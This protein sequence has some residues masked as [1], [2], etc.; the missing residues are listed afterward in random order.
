MEW[1][2]LDICLGLVA[3]ALIFSA[4]YWLHRRKLTRIDRELTSAE[5][6]GGP[7]Q[8]TLD[9]L[10]PPAR[11]LIEHMIAPDAPPV[12]AVRFRLDGEIKPGKT[13]G[14]LPIRST[15]TLRV[16]GGYTW[17]AATGWPMKLVGGDHYLD[18][19]GGVNFWLFGLLHIVRGKGTD[20]MRSAR[21]RA[22]CEAMWFPPALL[23]GEWLPGDIP[24][25]RLKLDG[26]DYTLRFTI[27]DNGRIT[28]VCG[29]RWG[30]DVG[31]GSWQKLKFGADF[32]GEVTADGY[33]IPTDFTAGWHYGTEQWEQG[34]FFK[35]TLTDVEFIK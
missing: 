3:F 11:R 31:D 15:E 8:R 12:R 6:L 4:S 21:G 2:V 27:A 1:V 17:R 5:P 20:V 16:P 10:P 35:A 19:D 33:T 25:C 30:D 7:D 23:A 14:W 18:N 13:S 22:G 34:Q 26:E 32:K 28:S 29:E 24:A 9:D